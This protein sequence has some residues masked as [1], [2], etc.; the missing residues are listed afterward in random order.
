MVGFDSLGIYIFSGLEDLTGSI[1]GGFARMKGFTGE[2]FW[3]QS[4]I[5]SK[6][7]VCLW[8]C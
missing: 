1:L 8:G 4:L 5:V 3:S 7:S 2:S 6:A